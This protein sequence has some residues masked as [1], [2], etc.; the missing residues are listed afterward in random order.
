MTVVKLVPVGGGGATYPFLPQLPLM[1]LEYK[2][3][4]TGTQALVSFLSA[5]HSVPQCPAKQ[6]HLI[7]RAGSKLV[8]SISLTLCES[9]Q[10]LKSQYLKYIIILK[11]CH[12]TGSNSSFRGHKSTFSF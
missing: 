10:I 12:H 8:E 9:F 4:E 5:F 7:P 3:E 6:R 2:W 11:N 1:Q